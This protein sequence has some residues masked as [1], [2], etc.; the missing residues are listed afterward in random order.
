MSTETRR[1]AVHDA[2]VLEIARQALQAADGDEVEAL[3]TAERSGLARFAA[4]EVHQPTL[5]ENLVVML[6]VCRDGKVGTAATNRTDE[7]GLKAAAALAG[8]A[9]AS[10]PPEPD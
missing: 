7:E 4:S 2:D 10:A 9:A 8:E 3:V 6:R 1:A 5:I